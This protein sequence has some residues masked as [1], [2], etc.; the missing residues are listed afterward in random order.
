[1]KQ[2]VAPC[3]DFN[4][5]LAVIARCKALD[6]TNYLDLPLMR[7]VLYDAAK[8][9]LLSREQELAIDAEALRRQKI[10][11]EKVVK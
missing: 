2:P 9:P 1:M 4:W 11:R 3:F 7:G 6:T 5:E 10:R 8:L